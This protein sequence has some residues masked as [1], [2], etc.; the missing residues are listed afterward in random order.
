M[1]A[2]LL[3][4]IAIC[5][6]R[7]GEPMSLKLGI[8]DILWKWLMHKWPWLFAREIKKLA[9]WMSNHSCGPRFWTVIKGA[10]KSRDLTGPEILTLIVPIMTKANFTEEAVMNMSMGRLRWLTAQI[11][12]F[13]GSERRFLWDKDLIDE[14][15]SDA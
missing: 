3:S 1:P 2:D 10:A 15:E 9:K 7:F 8:K 13:N 4:A 5:R 14:E 6:N 11:D 12:E